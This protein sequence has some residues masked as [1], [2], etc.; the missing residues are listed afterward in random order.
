LPQKNGEKYPTLRRIAIDYLACQA[1]SVPCE[2]IFSAGGEV[3]S[4]RRAQL[5]DVRFEKLVMMKFRWRNN[6]G[7]LAAWNSA[8]VEE[9]GEMVEYEDHL[10]AD[11]DHEEWDNSLADELV[12]N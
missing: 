1:S 5:G 12:V 7:D 8:K 3:A 9:V 10:T 2:H 6:I 4:N 11:Q